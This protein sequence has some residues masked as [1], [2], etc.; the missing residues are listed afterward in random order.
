MSFYRGTLQK[1]HSRMILSSS[2]FAPQP[3]PLSWF[4]SAGISA[5]HPAIFRLGH[6]SN[7]RR[8]AHSLIALERFFIDES[9]DFARMAPEVWL[10]V[11]C[12]AV[13]TKCVFLC[14]C[15][16]GAGRAA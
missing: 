5:D 9:C 16:L 14:V 6:P 2:D 11:Y 7:R 15:R 13:G 1:V 12:E 10:S 8:Y 3:G 4:P